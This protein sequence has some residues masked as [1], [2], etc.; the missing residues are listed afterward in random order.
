MILSKK[1]NFVFIHNYKV[2]GTSITEALKTH[3]IVNPPCSMSLL[4]YFENLNAI[5]NRYIF[6]LLR[7]MGVSRFHAHEKA[8]NIRAILGCEFYDSLYSFGFVRNP[9]DWQVSLYHFSKSTKKNRHYDLFNTFDGFDEYIEWRCANEV[10][11]QKDFF[12]YKNDQIVDFVGKIENFNKD[13]E[14]ISNKLGI[15]IKLNHSNKSVHR[16]WQEYYNNKT[17]RLVENAFRK[18]IELF[19]YEYE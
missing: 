17:R 8:F 4:N 1:N 13:I 9:W 6:Y 5:N 7:Y 16:H 11:L 10:R 2:G 19:E 12:Y 15:S 3:G 14:N 18:D